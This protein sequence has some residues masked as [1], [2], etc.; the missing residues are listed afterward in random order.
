[1]ANLPPYALSEAENERIFRDR[2]AP[3]VLPAS[4]GRSP[5]PTAIILGGQPG[6]GKT[7]LFHKSADE[8]WAKGPTVAIDG[9]KLRSFHPQYASLQRLEPLRAADHTNHDSGRWVEK[10]IEEAKQRGINLVIESTMRRPEVFEKTASELREAGY[11]IEA[12]A[13]AVN[14]RVSWQS[15]HSRYEAM[16]AAGE[17]PRFTIRESH[18]AGAKGVRETLAQIE[19]KGLADR[20]SVYARGSVII[21]DNHL[22]HGAWKEAARAAAALIEERNRPRTPNELSRHD[23]GWEKVL[24]M[25]TAR[26]APEA[27]QSQV[28]AQAREDREY[29]QAQVREQG[30]EQAAPKPDLVPA[31][32]IPDLTESEVQMRVEASGRLDHRRSEI[33]NLAQ[34]VYGSSGHDVARG[35]IQGIETSTAPS[36]KGT[37]LSD[38]IK[39][40]PESVGPLAGGTKGIFNR[41]DAERQ[42]ARAYAVQLAAAAQDYGSAV[43]VE[44]DRIIRDH[45][46]EQRQAKI[47]IPAPS[48]RLQGALTAEGPERVSRLQEAPI[49]AEMKRLDQALS[50]RLTNAD[51]RAIAGDRTDELSKTLGVKPETAQQVAKLF[52]QVRA[53]REMV[54]AQKIEQSRTQSGPV[55]SR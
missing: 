48:E 40:S 46:E 27:D 53:G 2:I 13:L 49:A 6:A 19:E 42:S 10:L 25:M 47:P 11:R 36:M 30:R 17:A 33:E 5:E 50:Q 8:L 16:I 26:G 21:Y 31:R 9:D 37:A 24:G 20:V 4:L 7:G 43:N 1:M 12:R 51:R 22:E 15:V 52:H 18:D 29:F 23:A 3:T 14:E 28:R 41:E 39:A 44:R 45:R 35:I 34:K 55:L 38:E 54:Q 32:V